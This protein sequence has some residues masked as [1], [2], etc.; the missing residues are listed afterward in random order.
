MTETPTGSGGSQNQRVVI[1]YLTIGSANQPPREMPVESLEEPAQPPAC[2]G[3]GAATAKAMTKLLIKVGSKPAKQLQGCF[4]C[5][6]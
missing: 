2:G 6:K 1:D 4:K 3:G 5:K